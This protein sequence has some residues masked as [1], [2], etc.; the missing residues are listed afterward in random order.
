MACLALR[1]RLGA[2]C[3]YVGVEPGHSAYGKD[4]DDV[5]VDVHGGLTYSDRC[6]DGPEERSIC[7]I[8]EPGTTDDVWWLGFDCAHAYDLAPEMRA[9]MLRAGIARAP[10]WDEDVYRTLAYVQGECAQ[11]AVQLAAVS[12]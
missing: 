2:W 6:F 9:L 1:N 3:G 10:Y 12:A 7:H 5:A 8:P 11:L 4:Y